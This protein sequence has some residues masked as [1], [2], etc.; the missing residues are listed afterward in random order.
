MN[1]RLTA[2]FAAAEA[3]LVLGVGLAIPLAITTLLWGFHFGFAPEWPVFGRAGVIVWL[4]GHGVDVTFTLDPEL[5]A[6][7][8][9]PG[10]GDPVTVTIA[11]LGIALLSFALAVRAGRRAAEAGHPVL[12]AA[13]TV[14]VFAAGSLGAAL[15]TLHPSA[16]ASLAQSAI[17][18]AL[19]VAAGVACGLLT[20]RDRRGDPIVPLPRPLARAPRGLVAAGGAALRVGLGSV[21]ALLGVAGLLTALAVALGFANLIAL[22]ETLQSGAF[23]G[24]LLTVLQLALVPLLVVWAAAWMVGPGFAVGVGS[25][26]S[27][28]ATAVGPIPPIPV[29]GALPASSPPFAFLA[30]V[31]PVVLGFLVGTVAARGAA[32]ALGPGARVLVGLGGGVVAGL[33]LGLLA[34]AAS[35]AAG[36]G[37][38]AV[39]GPDPVAVGA[40]FA[41]ET[42]VAATAGLLAARRAPV[43]RS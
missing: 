21:I 3:L 17:L 39:V 30:L 24:A 28:F 33:V 31:V 2:F 9:L 8:G 32:R 34:A 40:W 42:G 37:R 38:L 5:A 15:L 41:I 10:A 26:V 18:P 23:G 11:L 19:V 22:Y 4:L 7:L 16:R 35:G 13:V 1:R 36:P 27:P 14:A 29:L 20:A 43:L 12:G 6:G 25:T